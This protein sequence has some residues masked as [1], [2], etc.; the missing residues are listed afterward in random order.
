M[1]LEQH[2][3]EFACH[4]LAL[5]ELLHQ[6]QTELAVLGQLAQQKFRSQRAGRPESSER[7][8]CNPLKSNATVFRIQGTSTAIPT[9][10]DCRDSR[11]SAAAARRDCYRRARLSRQRQSAGVCHSDA[12]RHSGERS[13]VPFSTALQNHWGTVKRKGRRMAD[14]ARQLAGSRQS[15]L[16]CNLR[17]AAGSAPSPSLHASAR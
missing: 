11:D 16:P 14:L 17:S 6:E 15:A 8:C 10:R 3:V 12:T 1:L 7:S 9:C 4:A 5:G 13:W 2:Q